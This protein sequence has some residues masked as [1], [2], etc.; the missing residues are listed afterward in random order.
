MSIEDIELAIKEKEVR[1][2]YLE[3]SYRPFGKGLLT[4]DGQ[5]YSAEVVT[6]DDNYKVI[7]TVK[8]THPTDYVVDMIS[9]ILV[10]AGKSSGATEAITGLW[11]ASDDKV[12]WEA[13]CAATQRAADASA[14]SDYFTKAGQ[15]AL[16]GNYTGNG[17]ASYFRWK[18]KSDGAGGET[19]T[20][21]VKSS[22]L[23][24]IRY[25]RSA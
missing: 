14:Y 20:G 11:E 2:Q 8:I 19:A 25:K 23:I 17:T 9:L 4:S 12:D 1:P 21:K 6:T 10:A 15:F 13:L 5:Q 7:E 24:T 22:S 3:I 18:L 16:T